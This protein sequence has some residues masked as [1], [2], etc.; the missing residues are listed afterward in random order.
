MSNRLD[1]KM[2]LICV[3]LE[4]ERN[5]LAASFQEKAVAALKKTG[6]TVL[7]DNAHYTLTSEE[8]QRQTK[9]CMEKGAACIVYMT[10]TWVLAE[11]IVDAVKDIAVPVGIWGI[12]EP[13]SFSSVGANVVH[14]ILGEMNIPH[15]LF[16][17]DPDAEDVL[18]E[19]D[20][21]VSAAAIKKKLSCA[22]LGMI[23]GRAISA[24]PT[25]ADPNQIKKI[26]GTEV[27][28]IDQLILLEKARNIPADRC[29]SLISSLRERFGAVTADPE[30]LRRA[31]SVYFAL[32][33]MIEEYQ[34][35][36]L[37][38]K[39]I[40]EFMDHYCS[41]CLAL[42]LLNDE[43]FVSGCQC[44]LNAML[45]AYMHR[46]LSEDPHFFG[47]VNVVLKE[48]SAARVIN[49]GSVPSRL[50]ADP[51]D[52]MLVDQ[53][54]YMGAGRGVC[55]FF[56][57]KPGKVTFGTLGRV[58]G[59][60]EMNLASGEAYQESVEEMERVRTWAQGFIKLD[61]DPM[62]FYANLRCNHSVF[63]YGDYLPGLVKLCEL[64]DIPVHL[65]R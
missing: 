31:A 59:C 64:Y 51:K 57:C 65:N 20:T 5:D 44:N 4:G 9:E 47:D 53:Y 11:H 23:G 17:G 40:G 52:V 32:K 24:Y 10:G 3:G 25:A 54:E 6:L 36:M 7:N 37:T 27:E 26:F 34:L 55:T 22:R 42:M 45:S 1:K 63:G 28:H 62:K 56:C 41:C 16:C 50:A 46:Q 13:V 18:G 19:I 15:Q 39:C 58:N 12:P 43:G 60:Y 49:C 30:R 14:G 35:D 21:F 29:D 61:C 33:E 2:G 48:Q 38:V 8:V